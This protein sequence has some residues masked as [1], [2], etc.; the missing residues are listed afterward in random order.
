MAGGD[1]AEPWHPEHQMG[2]PAPSDRPYSQR[3]RGVFL[4][5]PGRSPALAAAQSRCAVAG[6]GT[7]FPPHDLAG[8]AGTADHRKPA[9]YRRAETFAAQFDLLS[10]DGV[11]GGRHRADGLAAMVVIV[12]AE[13]L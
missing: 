1:P 8:A 5:N 11:A 7:A 6:S 12:V 3:R 2:Y 9:D 13:F 10:E 4:G